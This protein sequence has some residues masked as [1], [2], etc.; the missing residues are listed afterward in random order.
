MTLR[1]TFFRPED[2]IM[3]TWS[4]Y[5]GKVVEYGS[6][7]KVS[8][9][10]ASFRPQIRDFRQ[11]QQTQT[12]D[13]ASLKRWL[14]Y[15]VQTANQW[16]LCVCLCEWHLEHLRSWSCQL[17]GNNWTT[18]K[19]INRE[20]G[21]NV[22]WGKELRERKKIMEWSRGSVVK[23]SREWSGGRKQTRNHMIVTSEGK[24]RKKGKE[25]VGGRFTP[26]S[27]RAW[28]SRLSFVCKSLLKLRIFLEHFDPWLRFHGQAV[29]AVV[30]WMFIVWFVWHVQIVRIN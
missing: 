18:I 19:G 2:M 3:L 21:K 30:Q 8:Q 23:G 9:R 15:C 26:F 14:Q 13:A 28:W 5:V 1:R 11:Q 10:I 29:H 22:K 4:D 7:S 25:I 24:G 6:R 17:I 16:T 12:R 27:V 20:K